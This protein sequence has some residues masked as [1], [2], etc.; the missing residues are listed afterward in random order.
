[1]LDVVEVLQFQDFSLWVC[2]AMSKIKVE[3]AY[4]PVLNVDI[5]KGFPV[6]PGL[7]CMNHFVPVFDSL[8]EVCSGVYF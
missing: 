7:F 4:C 6:S 3:R 8:P 1:M 2:V 5:V